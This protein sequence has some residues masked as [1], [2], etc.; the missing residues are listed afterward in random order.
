M[1]SDFIQLW[2]TFNHMPP[3]ESLLYKV[4][5]LYLFLRFLHNGFKNQN[6]LA[7]WAKPI[8]GVNMNKQLQ[9]TNWFN[10]PLSEDI[11]KYM[12]DDIVILHQLINFYQK[13]SHLYYSLDS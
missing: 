2:N 5:D 9:K 6:S 8:L 4:F 13:I 12:V 11:Q 7:P 1:V 10:T 3:T